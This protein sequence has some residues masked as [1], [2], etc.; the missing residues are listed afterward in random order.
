MSEMEKETKKKQKTSLRKAVGILL[1]IVV[2]G[3]VIFLISYGTYNK[4]RM[5]LAQEMLCG[6]NIAT[7]R[8]AMEKYYHENKEY[9][10]SGRWC[11]FL[12]KL[13]YIDKRAF[14]CEGALANGDKGPSHYS[15]NPNCDPNCPNDV[16]LL[17]ESRGGWNQCGGIELLSFDNHEG[18]GCY[19]LFNDFSIRFVKPEQVGKLNWGEEKKG[20]VEEAVTYLEEH[21]NEM[22]N[23]I[24]YFSFPVHNKLPL[25]PDFS[26]G[27]IRSE[28]RHWK[29]EYDE[30]GKL[31]KCEHHYLDE[32]VEKV[33][34]IYDLTGNLE[35]CDIENMAGDRNSQF[36]DE[37][38]TIQ[39][40]EHYNENGDTIKTEIFPD[41][42]I[43]K[44]FEDLLDY[45]NKKTDAV[46]Y[47]RELIA[48][49]YPLPQYSTETAQWFLDI[50]EFT[51]E[52]A[53]NLGFYTKAFYDDE[54]KIKNCFLFEGNIITGKLFF[55]YQED[56][57]SEVVFC[58]CSSGL[59]SISS[60]NRE[61]IEMNQKVYDSNG[62]LLRDELSTFYMESI[63]RD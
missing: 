61:G 3:L 12:V 30:T 39:R 49:L 37:E 38:N 35:R 24:R 44:R 27:K 20:Y 13:R 59:I 23:S 29:A 36:Y 32:V 46:K 41:L 43:K 54:G 17:F 42:S 14:I 48:M 52:E 58:H 55:I 11:D 18:K 45:E 4:I 7:L 56:T 47:F 19:I 31:R 2:I 50:N 34:Y 53:L 16:V 60:Y 10:V 22:G 40:I 8:S 62:Y 25:T 15:M 6:S 9:P 26:D 33:I 51:E 5:L 1:G 21:I 57:L 63:L 28:Q